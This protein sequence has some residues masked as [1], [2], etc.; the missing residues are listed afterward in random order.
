MQLNNF[1]ENNL[2]EAI[3]NGYNFIS[4]VFNLYDFKYIVLANLIT[5]DLKLVRIDSNFDLFFLNKYL[6]LNKT[7]I[8][9]ILNKEFLFKKVSDNSKKFN[10][11]INNLSNLSNN[12]TYKLD[13]KNNSVNK[14]KTKFSSYEDNIGLEALSNTSTY[15][16]HFFKF[17]LIEH[18]KSTINNVNYNNFKNFTLYCVNIIEHLEVFI[19]LLYYNSEHKFLKDIL[20]I[21][22]LLDDS[23]NKLD[24]KNIS[25]I[26]DT[27]KTF[28]VS[29]HLIKHLKKIKKYLNKSILISKETAFYNSISGTIARASGL[30][31][32]FNRLKNTKLGSTGS[33]Y[34]R[35]YIR[36]IDIVRLINEILKIESFDNIKFNNIKA[37][38]N[39]FVKFEN[40]S[41]IVFSYINYDSEEESLV[42]KLHF[43][44]LNNIMT[45][46][47]IINQKSSNFD[48]FLISINIKHEEL[49]LNNV[50]TIKDAI[51]N[52]NNY[53][54]RN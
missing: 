24:L 14:I 13:I 17:H 18:S 27:L 31:I 26:K 7:T 20:N 43:S 30:D 21:Y 29:N 37:F 36:Y 46:K 40:S 9:S 12:I 32:D 45:L 11:T 34:E 25:L 22:N 19:K 15:M 5:Y 23:L 3:N 35:F 47:H 51:K 53:L 42:L 54:D 33:T 44:S 48:Y 8:N 52:I 4:D 2:F 50:F 10:Y 38:N 1:E 28:L 39:N 49:A 6:I 41:G 16:K